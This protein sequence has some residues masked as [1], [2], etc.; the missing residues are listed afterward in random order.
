MRKVLLWL[1]AIVIGVP[2]LFFGIA[3]GTSWYL[4]NDQAKKLARSLDPHIHLE[5]AGADSALGGPIILRDVRLRPAGVEDEIRI[6]AVSVRSENFRDWY[7]LLRMFFEGR[8]PERLEMDLE[9]IRISPDGEIA[10]RLWKAGLW[11][12]VAPYAALGC[13]E[14]GHF[15]KDA[16]A[17]LRGSE[18]NGR[19]RYEFDRG[20][21]DLNL[22]LRYAV[23]KAGSLILDAAV[24][25]TGG[26][27]LP[28]SVGPDPEL[29]SLSLVVVDDA[30]HR[31]RNELCA[32]K[33]GMAP[34]DVAARHAEALTER[35]AEI[36]IPTGPVLKEALRQ[37][38]NQGG[39]VSLSALPVR[40]QPLSAFV[41]SGNMDWSSVMNLEKRRDGSLIV[42]E[43]STAKE[44]ALA[45][46]FARAIQA[47]KDRPD[48]FRPVAVSDLTKYPQKL[49]K[50][51][52]LKGRVFNAY[53]E[54]VENQSLVLTQHLTG[55][56]ATF[57][58]PLSEVAK[59]YVLY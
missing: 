56:R 55:G 18:A 32:R 17:E 33:L 30:F 26:V 53:L 59:I 7:Q 1:A 36:G 10:Q 3:R 37:F 4:V 24:P 22:V 47:G 46:L 27:R 35:L 38:A 2:L 20:R 57:V 25:G 40:P 29:R 5:Y 48:R 19:I 39:E 52:T 16:L 44:H 34:E 8:L 14:G 28:F 43:A 31:R 49:L 13:F 12:L 54:R 45:A 6:G 42:E 50:I 15:D 58:T 23:P 41:P 21:N 51:H 11:P 9:P